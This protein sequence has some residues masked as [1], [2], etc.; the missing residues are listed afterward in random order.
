MKRLFPLRTLSY[1][2]LLPLGTAQAMDLQQAY[3]DALRYDA[4]WASTREQYAASEENATQAEAALLPQVSASGTLS[5]IHISPT[6]QFPAFGLYNRT[7]T[8]KLATV[9]AMQPLFNGQAWASYHAARKANSAATAQF[10]NDKQKF[11]LKLASAYFDVLRARENLVYQ[12]AQEKAIGRQL[13]QTQKRFEVGLVA[14]TEVHEAQAAFDSA[15]ADRISAET[16]VSSA[17]LNLATLTGKDQ[18]ALAILRSDAPVDQLPAHSETDW[19]TLAVQENP[20]I[21]A[22]RLQMQ[23]AHQQVLAA[24]AGHLPTLALVGNWQDANTSGAN[25]FIDGRTT[26]VGLQLSVPLYEG[27][28]TQSQVRQA[29]DKENAARDQLDLAQRVAVQ[30]TRISYLSVATDAARVKARKQ[31]VSSSAAALVATE[32]GYDVGT[33][34]IVEVMQA[35]RDLYAAKSA[36]ANARYDYVIDGLRLKA[37]AGQLRDIDISQLNTWLDAKGSIDVDTLN[38]E[39]QQMPASPKAPGT[40]PPI[41]RHR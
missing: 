4:G 30:S 8:N 18:Q 36:Y 27:G 16:Q 25:P 19:S 41:P 5:S 3:Q 7:Y 26:S 35:Q 23:A 38:P 12:Q 29:L 31:A 39:I 28:L 6:E 14:I 24:R 22:A 37:A 2:L 20:A 17:E 34:D 21:E 11:M 13:E 1:C 15:V 10:E 9:Q 33:R 40:T 32:A